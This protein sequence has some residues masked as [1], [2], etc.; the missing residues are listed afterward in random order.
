MRSE[1]FTVRIVVEKSAEQPM[2]MGPTIV[3]AEAEQRN[4]A[5]SRIWVSRHTDADVIR[6][7]NV[8]AGRGIP[9][10]EVAQAQLDELA[11]RRFHGGVVA[12]VRGRPRRRLDSGIWAII[13]LSVPGFV[14]AAGFWGGV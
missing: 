3:L 9:I 5:I 10:E 1:T 14:R 12:E 13:G 8:A 11:G 2:L 6:E 7:L 4:C